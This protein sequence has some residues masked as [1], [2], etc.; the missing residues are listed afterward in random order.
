MDDRMER[1]TVVAFDDATAQVALPPR[2]R[3]F[4]ERRSRSSLPAT[5]LTVAL[6]AIVVGAALWL[7]ADGRIVPAAPSAKP[8]PSN[9]IL[10]TPGGTEA[11]TWGKVWS[12]SM[13][14][15]VLRPAWLPVTDSDTSYNVVTSSNGLH[16]YVVGYYQ[17]NVFPPGPRPPLLLFIGEGPDVLPPQLGAGESSAN[18]TVRGQAG[19]LVTAPD[20]APRVIWTENGIRYMVQAVV[21]ITPNDVLRLVESLA[22]VVDGDGNTR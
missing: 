21:G 2:E 16:R 13:G 18:L 6:V 5:A 12:V 20:G 11:Q 7:V 15:T 4:P 19:R 1:W 3:W 10:L 9:L 22:P 8:A 14:A 17:K